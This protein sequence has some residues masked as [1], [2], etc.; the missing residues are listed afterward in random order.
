MDRPWNRAGVAAC[1]VVA[2]LDSEGTMLTQRTFARLPEPGQ[3]CL[4]RQ[5]SQEVWHGMPQA[6]AESRELK[7]VAIADG[8]RDNWTFLESLTPDIRWVDIGQ[9]CPSLK[10]A[11]DAAIGAESARSTAGF[12][13]HKA[14]LTEDP[15]GVGQMID[16][17][18][19][20]QRKSPGAGEIT[21]AIGYVRSHRQR[22]RDKAARDAGS[23]IGSGAVEAANKMIVNTR[24]KRSGPRWGRAGGQGVLTFRALLKSGCFDSVWAQLTHR[25]R[26]AHANLSANDNRTPLARVA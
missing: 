10:A 17:L 2:P 18:R 1:G 5:I 3:T 19:Y 21:T 6:A 23:P 12:D 24:L 8:A 9:A 20:L 4:K 15:Q 25:R 13:T 14:I 22:M 7:I 26:H 16:A 11:V